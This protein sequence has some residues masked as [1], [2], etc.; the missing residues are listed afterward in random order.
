MTGVN[1]Y[2]EYLVPP[3]WVFSH[4]Y[5]IEPHNSSLSKLSP[6]KCLQI[7]V[8]QSQANIF[9]GQNDLQ[10]EAMEFRIKYLK[11]EINQ[12]LSLSPKDKDIE[13]KESTSLCARSL[14]D[15]DLP[16]CILM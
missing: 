14:E 12:W 10:V 2:L 15:S 3:S 6:L 5:V 4:Q 13:A 7:M 11:K 1:I 9:K 16:I 8:L